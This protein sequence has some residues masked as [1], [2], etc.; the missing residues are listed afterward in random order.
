MQLLR[1]VTGR[2]AVLLLA[3]LGVVVGIVAASAVVGR[4]SPP[5]EAAVLPSASVAPTSGTAT[6][7][8]SALPSASEAPSSAPTGPAADP[9]LGTDGR[10]TVLLL[11]SDYRPAHPGNRT[12]TIMVVSVDSSTG[13]VAA[14]SIPRDTANFPLPGGGVYRAKVNG[15]YQSLLGRLGRQ[16]AGVEIKRAIGTAIGVE[17]DSYALVGFAGVQRLVDA[18]G[19][20]DVVLARTVHDPDYWVTSTRRGVTFPKGRNHLTGARALIFA[21]TRKGDNDFER[22]RRQQLLVAAALTAVRER[23]LARLPA[24]VA[25]ARGVVQTDLPLAAAPAIYAIVSGANVTKAMKVVFGPTTWASSLGGT[26]FALKLSAVRAW[27]A[28]WMAPVVA[29]PPASSSPPP[30]SSAATP[31]P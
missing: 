29:A 17:I 22:A 6:A 20:V 10:F 27:T 21:R 28:R 30:P 2:R 5:P 16:A 13:S 26:S 4:L 7:T 25:A 19:G 18:V 31:Q 9:V 8:P 3:A 24:L 14:A 12:D 15:L 1:S 23:G 11:G